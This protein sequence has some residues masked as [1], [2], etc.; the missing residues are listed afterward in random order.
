MRP[1]DLERKI[2]LLLRTELGVDEEVTADTE[3]ITTGLIDSVGLVRLATFLEREID[4]T[5]DNQDITV[6]NFGTLRRIEA[7]VQR[8]L[9]A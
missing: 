5:V 6:D 7:Y 8:R 2:R 3:L 4:I 9:D 1:E